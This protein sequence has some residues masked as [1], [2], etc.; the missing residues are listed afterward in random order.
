VDAPAPNNADAIGIEGEIDNQ[1]F[2]LLG[3]LRRI[4]VF[5]GVP[6]MALVL[7]LAIWQDGPILLV[8]F[9]L[10]L[11]IVLAARLWGLGRKNMRQVARWMLVLF[12]L[13]V[14]VGISTFGPLFGTGMMA[15][16]WVLLASVFLGG[17]LP[18]AL[19]CGAGV[20]LPGVLRA[21]DWFSLPWPMIQGGFPAW[22]RL[23][24]NATLMAAAA[25]FL[26]DSVQT[27]LARALARA[28]E[29]RR[30]EDAAR[31]EREAARAAL[32]RAQHLE[33]VGRLAGGV[34]HDVNN[35]LTVLMGGLEILTE[36]LERLSPE[37]CRTML[38]DMD[39]AA[40]GALA[41]TR[42]LLT[43]ARQREVPGGNSNPADVLRAMGRNLQRLLPAHIEVTLELEDAEVRVPMSEGALEQVVLNLCLN[44]RD[45]MP[46]G[47]TLS[48]RFRAETSQDPARAV[49]TVGDEGTGMSASTVGRVFEPFF[50]TKANE[51]GTGLG[52][53]MARQMVEDAGGRVE[54]VSAIG[55]GTTVRVEL[56]LLEGA[57]A[58][59]DTP[60]LGPRRNPTRRGRI[61][62]LEDEPGVA[63]TLQR[64]LG[65]A[66]FDV[67]HVSTVGTAIQ[68]VV[69]PS[70]GAFITDA[71]L[72][73]GDPGEAI[74]RFRARD[75]RPVIVHSGYLGGEKALQSVELSEC[76]F[77]QKPA[78]GP[79]LVS[80]LETLLE[81]RERRASASS[82]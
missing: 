74:R 50:T 23:T 4:T 8:S 30:R 34:A 55:T 52:L 48:L 68:R 67:D 14:V 63:S 76:T 37:E 79:L 7:A 73:D 11:T 39:T 18:Q 45:A 20:L 70:Y 13:V 2:R 21:L 64:I 36:D 5:G 17:W 81:Q 42:Q 72:P 43:F 35:A 12:G 3:F 58:P 29:L 33:S 27:G 6:V 57:E 47:G 75:Q 59:D 66:G 28:A 24:I 1:R 49:L 46:D 54:L 53:S 62:V 19:A 38:R 51:L 80:T 82:P 25:A 56:P 26:F 32:A 15:L 77:L 61:L 40:H 10:L 69:D 60:A 16:V 65:R 44:A 9:N 71:V 41:T 22:I 78:P 31:G